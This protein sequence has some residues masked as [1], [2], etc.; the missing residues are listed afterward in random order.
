MEENDSSLRQFSFHEVCCKYKT[1]IFCSCCTI[2]PVST[3]LLVAELAVRGE[4]GPPCFCYG[5]SGSTDTVLN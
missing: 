3:G 5:D 4:I 2:S 1:T